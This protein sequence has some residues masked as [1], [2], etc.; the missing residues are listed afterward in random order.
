M[1]INVPGEPHGSI[2]IEPGTK[3]FR[4]VLRS[5]FFSA[6]ALCV[7]DLRNKDD[8]VLKTNSPAIYQPL[9]FRLFGGI[10]SILRNCLSAPAS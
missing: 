4:I 2:E 7:F 6:V 10:V 9:Q 5:L 3:A 1:R 8:S